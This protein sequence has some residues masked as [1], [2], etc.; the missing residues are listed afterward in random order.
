[1]NSFK[2][3]FLVIIELPYGRQTQKDRQLSMVEILTIQT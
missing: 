1:M 3:Q 2:T